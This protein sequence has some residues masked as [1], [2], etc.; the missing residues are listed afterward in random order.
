[1]GPQV[2]AAFPRDPLMWTAMLVSLVIA[3]FL[4]YELAP[5]TPPP[6]VSWPPWVRLTWLFVYRWFPRLV[7]PLLLALGWLW[8][9]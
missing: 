6:A 8:I 2:V 9:S 7:M 3:A 5:E 4:A 1:M